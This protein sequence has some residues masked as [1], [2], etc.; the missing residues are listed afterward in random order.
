MRSTET[1]P[2]LQ[3]PAAVIALTRAVERAPWVAL[4]LEF[5]SQ[6]RYWPELCVLQL[7]IGEH[8][9]FDADLR[10]FVAIEDV[11]QRGAWGPAQAALG[12]QALALVDTRAVGLPGQAL[13]QAPAMRAELLALFAA[14]AAHPLTIAHAPR[15]D[16]AIIA[17]HT[18]SRFTTVFD[19]QTAAAFCGKGDQVG[20]AKLVEELVGV[21]L[22][23]EQQWTDWR[24][25]PL[26]AA[27]LGYAC[28]DVRYL[29][30]M[31]RT[32]A[33][34]L[35]AHLTWVQAETQAIV[36]A[37]LTAAELDPAHAW[38]DV[39]GLRGLTAT[40]ARIAMATA[41]WRLR[42]GRL[43]NRPLGHILD[44]QSVGEFARRCQTWRGGGDV[45]AFLAEQ[46]QAARIAPGQRE[47][48]ASEIAATLAA[49]APVPD[50]LVSGPRPPSQGSGPLSPRA[51]KWAEQLLAIA[52]LVAEETHIPVRFW[53]T[54]SEAE[55]FARLYDQGGPAA[56]AALPAVGS[57]RHERLGA[58]WQAWLAGQAALVADRAASVG[59]RWVELASVTAANEPPVAAQR[60]NPRRGAAGPR[61]PRP[62]TARVAS[63]PRP[64]AQARK[65][66]AAPRATPAGPRG[67]GAARTTRGASRAK[68]ASARSHGKPA[69]P[70]RA[71][72]VKVPSKRAAAAK[73]RVRQSARGP[74]KS[75]RGKSLVR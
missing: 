54:R 70:A 20:Y 44:D 73:A 42:M 17:S 11:P 66:A 6:D 75:L 49:N 15:Q 1:P 55:A 8:P 50:S 32:L 41:A 53:A 35:G 28:D 27:Q 69:A 13:P 16:L 34:T 10:Q 25:R 72:A 45:E 5:W 63:V 48:L 61:T 68:A 3:D 12:R 14:L 19:T 4:D 62:A 43:H 52:A 9:D 31:Y 39:N 21:Q 60:T 30:P 37:A 38:R 51:S 18:A 58:R 56:V 64:A 23:K 59:V 26:S 7:A 74:Q 71:P 36:A 46:M 65:Q 57:W 22:S 67:A 2:F 40:G 33:G 24:R 47:A 29:Y